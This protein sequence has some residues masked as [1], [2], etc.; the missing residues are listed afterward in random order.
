MIGDAKTPEEAERERRLR[1]L[2]DDG[3]I[4]SKAA[5]TKR[6]RRAFLT[7]GVLGVAGYAGFNRLQN[8]EEDEA[9]PKLLR[10]GLEWNENVWERIQR[11]GASARTFSIADREEIRVNGRHGIEDNDRDLIEIGGPDGRELGDHPD[12]ARRCPARP[13]PARVDQVRLRGPRH[14][15]GAQVR[16][17][18]GEHR[19]LDRCPLLRR[20]RA[21]CARRGERRVDGVA[22]S[23]VRPTCAVDYSSAIENYTMMHH[24]TLLAW[25][26]NG[27]P[28]TAGHGDP[29]RIV[30]PFKYGIKQLKRIASI[31]FTDDRPTDYWTERGYDLHAGF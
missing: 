28:L 27:E 4:I 5:Y 17:G 12:R 21:V 14:G 18:M 25:Q 31:E 8:Q 11:D 16:R 26:L 13:D 23:G 24:Q 3:E 2:T 22:D 15:V 7:F 30:T 1:E 10:A 9:I 19:A 6:S 20:P 29:I